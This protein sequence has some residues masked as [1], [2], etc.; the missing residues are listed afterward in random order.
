MTHIRIASPQVHHQHIIWDQ[1]K[2]PIKSFN[3]VIASSF[4]VPAYTFGQFPKFEKE[5][6]FHL[7]LRIVKYYKGKLFIAS[8]DVHYLGNRSGQTRIS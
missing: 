2:V 1:R 4:R 5:V 7:F 3:N 8:Q 6:Q